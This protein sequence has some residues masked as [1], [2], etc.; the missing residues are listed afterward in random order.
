[1]LVHPAPLLLGDNLSVWCAAN[2]VLTI[3]R[4]PLPLAL[5]GAGQVERGRSDQSALS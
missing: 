1:V 4:P 3:G 5:G 2:G